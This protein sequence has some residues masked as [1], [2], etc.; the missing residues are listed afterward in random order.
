MHRRPQR[1]TVKEVLRIAVD[2]E[3]KTM[4]LYTQFTRAFQREEELRKFW[5]SMARHEAGHIGALALVESVL[6]NEPSLAEGSQ[7]WF[8]PSTVVRLRSL[9]TAYIKE[10]RQGLSVERSF[11]MAIDVEGLELED[12]VM[13]LLHV[14]KEKMLRDQAV[15]LLIHDLS[16][17]SYMIEKFTHNETLL[18]RADELVERR[19]DT[20][21]SQKEKRTSLL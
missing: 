15:Q 21:T 7:V 16:D 2:L 14:V 6:D 1:T 13:E 5:F 17:L 4:G 19:V 10:A 18:A 11:E 8:D 9:L 3:K 12:V 20:L